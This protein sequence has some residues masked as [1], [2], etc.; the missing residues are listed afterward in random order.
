MEALG[1]LAVMRG[2]AGLSPRPAGA[3]S[4]RGAEEMTVQVTV[5]S[6]CGQSPVKT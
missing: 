3:R 6:E 1:V 4:Q 2:W 5:R